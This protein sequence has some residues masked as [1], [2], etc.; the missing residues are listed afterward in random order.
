M[1]HI[2]QGPRIPPSHVPMRFGRMDW[3]YFHKYWMIKQTTY[4]IFVPWCCC[5][6]F[7]RVFKY[8]QIYISCLGIKSTLRVRHLK[9]FPSLLSP[10]W[11]RL[12]TSITLASIGRKCNMICSCLFLESIVEVQVSKILVDHQTNML[13]QILY[14]NLDHQ[15]KGLELSNFKASVTVCT[16]SFL[17]V[18]IAWA[19]MGPITCLKSFSK[20]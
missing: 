5:V 15:K 16:S 12:F 14:Y 11:F 6:T 8:L 7:I 4:C 17:N 9:I 2:S 13:S 20:T 10:T 18:Q 3:K 19:L 1:D